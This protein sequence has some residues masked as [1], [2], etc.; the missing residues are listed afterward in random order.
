MWVELMVAEVECL[1]RDSGRTG[2][3]D[4]RQWVLDWLLRPHPALAGNEPEELLDTQEHR[5]I[6]RAMLER[7]RLGA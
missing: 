1:A 4:A 2:D 7:M 5:R 3:F 6:L